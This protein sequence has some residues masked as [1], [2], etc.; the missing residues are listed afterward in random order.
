MT[1]TDTAD[2]IEHLS[3][4]ITNSIERATDAITKTLE[5]MI[6]NLENTLTR[7]GDDISRPLQ[8]IADNIADNAKSDVLGEIRDCMMTM[9]DDIVRSVKITNIMDTLGNMGNNSRDEGLVPEDDE[10]EFDAEDDEDELEA[11]NNKNSRKR[12]R[13]LDNPQNRSPAAKKPRGRP[14]KVN[15]DTTPPL[16]KPRGRPPK[17]NKDTT[18]PLNKPRGRPPKVKKDTPSPLN[19]P[20]GRPPKVNKDTTPPPDKYS[21]IPLEEL[22]KKHQQ[23]V[24]YTRSFDDDDAWDPPMRPILPK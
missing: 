5:D 13:E 16:N 15:K 17:V 19:K 3:F 2:A 9:K 11:Q 1:S 12:S 10:D 18:S 24:N 21:H 23:Q 14:P 8:L 7:V 22:K 20:R 6:W 4:S